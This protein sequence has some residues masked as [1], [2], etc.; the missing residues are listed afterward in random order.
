MVLGVDTVTPCAMVTGFVLTE[1][2][3]L[4]TVVL[5]LIFF[6]G[7]YLGGVPL[8]SVLDVR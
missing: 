5:E 2:D 4:L 1:E 8:S 7:T 6:L 3:V